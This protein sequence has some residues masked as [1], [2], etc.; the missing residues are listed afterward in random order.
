MS[1]AWKQYKLANGIGGK[2]IT[3]GSHGN[4]LLN[5]NTNYGY[6]LVDKNT[7]EILKIG[8]AHV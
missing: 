4:S 5:P 3:P 8:R 7:G 1:E 2:T 6:V